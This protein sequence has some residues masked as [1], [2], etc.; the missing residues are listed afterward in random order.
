MDV[1]KKLEEIMNVD[2]YGKPFNNW[3]RLMKTTWQRLMNEN[4]KFNL[5]PENSLYPG[6]YTE[7]YLRSK[8][9]GCIPIYFADPHVKNDFRVNSFINI[10]DFLEFEKLKSHLFEIKND[11]DYLSKLANE[12]LLED[13]PNLDNIKK[14]YLKIFLKLLINLLRKFIC[15][16]FVR[17][18][19]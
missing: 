14:F 19:F 5:C 15:L 13:I 12:P 17:Y 6:Y 7:K 1:L 2:A 4:Y 10:Y 9:A 18:L 11:F 16:F 3:F 8:I